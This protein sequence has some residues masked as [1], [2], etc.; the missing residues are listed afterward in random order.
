M[1][2]HNYP[3]FFPNLHPEN[4]TVT[5]PSSNGYNCIAWA[6]Q[7]TTL[8]WEPI[9]RYFWPNSVPK[10]PGIASLIRL[11]EERGYQ[12]CSD[13]SI[14]AGFEK[15]ALYS[16]GDGDYTHAARQLA[17]GKWTSKLGTEEDIEHS[18]PADIAGGKYGSV[19]LYMRR[20]T[21]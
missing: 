9:D 3:D 19:E 4:Y 17:N 11:F 7:D 10:D 13:G 6:A 5:S 1:L 15:V 16:V 18:A 21:T 20:Q 2:P 8:W 14:E 12:K